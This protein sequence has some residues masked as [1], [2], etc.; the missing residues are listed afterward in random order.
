MNDCILGENKILFKSKVNK[1]DKASPRLKPSDHSF[2]LHIKYR[3]K[4]FIKI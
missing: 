2:K 1:L 4:K 3:N